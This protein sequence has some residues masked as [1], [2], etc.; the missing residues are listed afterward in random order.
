MHTIILV[1]L[2]KNYSLQAFEALAFTKALKDVYDNNIP[3]ALIYPEKVDLR[4]FRTSHLYG[5][6]HNTLAS[7][8]ASIG[9]KEFI[10]SVNDL[11]KL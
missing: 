2:V 9:L 7:C 8:F 10:V 4:A 1:H 5:K 11:K 3:R 6:M